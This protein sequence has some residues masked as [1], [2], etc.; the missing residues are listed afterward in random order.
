MSD[1]AMNGTIC[2]SLLLILLK[3]EHISLVQGL[4]RLW[5]VGYMYLC[6]GNLQNLFVVP[7]L[8]VRVFYPNPICVEFDGKITT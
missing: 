2:R 4:E 5:Y 7:W 1:L 3:Q 6:N 8:S